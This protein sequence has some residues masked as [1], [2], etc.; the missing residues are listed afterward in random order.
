M[1]RIRY[2]PRPTYEIECLLFA[3]SEEAWFWFIRCQRLRSEGARL[4][5]AP[6]GIPRPCSP[7][8]I[9]LSV[10]SLLRRRFIDMEHLRVL[11]KYGIRE[12]PPDPRCCREERHAR[13]WDEALDRL[14]TVLR[15]KGISA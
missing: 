4:E 8:D 9:Y 15:E 12:L 7:D 6:D 11:W 13:L 2:N 5:N 3:N 10:M 14:T 1:G